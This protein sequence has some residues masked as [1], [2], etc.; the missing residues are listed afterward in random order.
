[1]RK[2]K[3]EQSKE[4]EILFTVDGGEKFLRSLR[5]WFNRLPF[6]FFFVIAASLADWTSNELSIFSK[7]KRFVLLSKINEWMNETA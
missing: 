1:M 3:H 4:I 7:H 5:L 2:A 6:F